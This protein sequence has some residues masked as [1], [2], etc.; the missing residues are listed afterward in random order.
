MSTKDILL[1]TYR[2]SVRDFLRVWDVS[3]R[4]SELPDL[5]QVECMRRALNEDL[6]HRENRPLEMTERREAIRALMA[7]WQILAQWEKDGHLSSACREVRHAIERLRGE[8][9]TNTDPLN[10]VTQ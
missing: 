9:I 7:A 3:N 10:P 2:T 8:P 1:D 6:V 4:D 5:P